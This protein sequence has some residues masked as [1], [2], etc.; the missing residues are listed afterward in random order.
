MTEVIEQYKEL[1]NTGRSIDTKLWSLPTAAFTF[2]ALAIQGYLM[3]DSPD[4]RRFVAIVAILIFSGFLIQLIRF[5]GY[6]LNCER[7][8]K[9]LVRSK[10]PGLSDVNQFAGLPR[11]PKNVFW[12]IR[13]V[14]FS[15]TTYMIW[16]MILVF[17]ANCYAFLKT[18]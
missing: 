17:V 2:E 13:W 14:R 7:A 8:I 18:L 4:G 5:R 9:E 1:C 11:L 15:S 16:V 3:F 6:Q 12:L 10:L